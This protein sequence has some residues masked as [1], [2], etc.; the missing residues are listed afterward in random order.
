MK[1]ALLDL[2]TKLYRF[3]WDCPLYWWRTARSKTIKELKFPS[4]F[5]VTLATNELC[6]ARCI[7][8]AY[9]HAA[10]AGHLDSKSM[11]PLEMSRKAIDEVGMAGGTRM[12]FA[13]IVGDPLV[14]PIIFDRVSYAA[15]VWNLET[16]LCTNGILLPKRYKEAIDS[17]LYMLNIS[18]GGTNREDYR[19]VYG[20]DS[21]DQVIE[22]VHRVLRYNQEQGEKT[23]VNVCFRPSQTT[24]SILESDDYKKKIAPYL[25]KQ[26]TV[27]FAFRMVNWGGWI[28]PEDL[29]GQLVFA[30]Q[31]K[32]RGQPC[33]GL[34]SMILR[35]DGTVRVC[36]CAFKKTPGDEMT[37]GTFPQ[38]SLRELAK[39]SNQ[40][41]REFR[42]GK[43]PEVCK[44]CTNFTP[45]HKLWSPL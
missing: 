6:N 14:D 44:T 13:P 40:L 22:G 28:K 34:H 25:S 26:N 20:V 9:P 36:G 4:D 10:D 8:C 30:N 18:V 27:K 41:L 17:G 2:R 43:L 35:H 33:H 24:K 7:F 5:I 11:M 16:I 29:K 39:Y 45:I 31:P 21:Y 32:F 19:E 42:E 38:K 23:N 3:L 1:A 15:K 12:G 37:V